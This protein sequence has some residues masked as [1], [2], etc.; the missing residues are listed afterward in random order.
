M[1]FKDAAERVL[2][3]VGKPMHSREIVE[4]ALKMRWVVSKGK[5]PHHTLQAV[6]WSDIEKKRAKSTFRMVGQGRRQ[7][8]FW[9][10]ELA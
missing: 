2:R 8:K 3:T 6:I 10:R 5:T 9:L 4:Y 7:R 1:T